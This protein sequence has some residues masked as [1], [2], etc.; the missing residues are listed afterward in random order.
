MNYELIYRSGYD[1]HHLFRNKFNG[2]LVIADHSNDNL[3][4]DPGNPEG[5]DDG[6]L[7]VDFN[8]PVEVYKPGIYSIPMVNA[9]GGQS[10]CLGKLV[11]IHRI[12]DIEER[13]FS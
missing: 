12:E 3:I 11:E 1:G 13:R 6:L 5:T 10:N 4:G 9:D 7:Y 2:R 8:R